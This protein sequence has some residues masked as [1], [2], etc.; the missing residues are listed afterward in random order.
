MSTLSPN[1]SE[2]QH[3][4]LKVDGFSLISVKNLADTVKKDG[5]GLDWLVLTLGMATIQGFTPTQD[6]FDQKLQLHVYSRFLLG[7]QI[8][9]GPSLPFKLSVY[10]PL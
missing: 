5:L 10:L 8:S 7:E 3:R 2:V 6:G 9:S 4:F 1:P